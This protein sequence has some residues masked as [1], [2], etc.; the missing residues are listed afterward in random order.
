M[1]FQA[2]TTDNELTQQYND[3]LCGTRPSMLDTCKSLEALIEQNLK[4]LDDYLLNQSSIAY[5]T[6][7]YKV[8]H[9][10][11]ERD[12]IINTYSKHRL[13]IKMAQHLDPR[14]V[15]QSDPSTFGAGGETRLYSNPA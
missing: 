15:L 6:I 1:L 11:E 14:C 9:T 3:N 13:L 7:E 4:D 5:E 10:D 8:E 12:A 2:V